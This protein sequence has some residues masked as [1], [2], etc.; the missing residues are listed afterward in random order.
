MQPLVRREQAFSSTSQ[1]IANV[2]QTEAIG[3]YIDFEA[4]FAVGRA[5]LPQTG[6]VLYFLQ[7]RDR[8]FSPVRRT[9]QRGFVIDYPFEAAL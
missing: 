9:T 4:T 1:V 5:L 8:A 7:K 2:W 6:E 3:R